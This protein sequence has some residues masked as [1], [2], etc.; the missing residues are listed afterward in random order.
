MARMRSAM[1]NGFAECVS[2]V[3]VSDNEKFSSDATEL[4]LTTQYLDLLE[5]VAND[6]RSGQYRNETT[7]F[8]PTGIDSIAKMRDRLSMFSSAFK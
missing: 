1:V 3:N 7:M 8:L 2:T 4:L 6:A 5:E